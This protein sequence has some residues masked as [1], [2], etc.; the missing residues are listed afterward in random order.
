M[1]SN[2]NQKSKNTHTNLAVLITGLLFI[3]IIELNEDKVW[4]TRKEFDSITL[5]E[6]DWNQFTVYNHFWINI[7]HIVILACYLFV[8]SSRLRKFSS[9]LIKSDVIL[10]FQLI[11][12]PWSIRSMNLSWMSNSLPCFAIIIIW[13][14]GQIKA[15]QAN[16]QSQI[17]SKSELEAYFKAWFSI[18]LWQQ[19]IVCSNCHFL[20]LDVTAYTI[21][22]R[23]NL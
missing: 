22:K 14:I 21:N 13:T 18:Q 8:F 12:S 16:Y 2:I 10:V 15:N 17:V 7:W 3:I 19:I 6:Y 1:W 5:T 4:L 9:W 11:H 23:G 20:V